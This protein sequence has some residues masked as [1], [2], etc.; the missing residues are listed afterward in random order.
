MKTL[1]RF[2]CCLLLGFGSQVAADCSTTKVTNVKATLNDKLICAQAPGTTDPNHRWSEHLV[3]T[4][5]TPS[6]SSGNTLEWARGT[7]PIDPSQI[8]GIWVINDASDTIQFYYN[9]GETYLYTV[10]NNGGAPT[11]YSF[12]EGTTEKAVGTLVTSPSGENPCN[13]SN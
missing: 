13:W 10:Y 2:S 12:C 8:V 4:T 3:V 6:F 5:N 11:T 9:A 7:N 1:A